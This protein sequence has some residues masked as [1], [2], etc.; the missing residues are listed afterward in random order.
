M[1]LLNWFE[2]VIEYGYINKVLTQYAQ[3]SLIE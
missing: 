2:E 1:V 3:L